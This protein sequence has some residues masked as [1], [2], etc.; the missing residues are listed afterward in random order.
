MTRGF[1]WDA[2]DEGRSL[3]PAGELLGWKLLQAGEGHEPF[4]VQF[5]GKPE[6][7][8]PAGHIQGGILAAMLDETFSPALASRLAS[9]EFP[10]TLEFKVNFIAPARVGV[11][12][13]E[14]RIVRKG[15]SV[16]F[17]E[18]SLTDANGELLATASATA[19][20]HKRPERPASA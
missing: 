7:R 16:C 15:K 12:F 19:R 20:V 6:F 2:V 5:D 13:G 8:N 1:F 11:I 4:R 17:L 14:A 10:A 18:A 9:D 3:C